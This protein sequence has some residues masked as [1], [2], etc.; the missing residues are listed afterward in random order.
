MDTFYPVKE[1]PFYIC[2]CFI[3]NEYWM[4]SNVFCNYWDDHRV[5][6]LLSVNVLITLITFLMFCIFGTVF[7]LLYQSD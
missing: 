3:M 5:F 6:L 7:A 1:I 2:E 4:L